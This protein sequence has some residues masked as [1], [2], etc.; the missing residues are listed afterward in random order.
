M[1]VATPEGGSSYNPMHIC[2]AVFSF[3]PK[4]EGCQGWAA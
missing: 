4:A 3:Y 2:R 1:K